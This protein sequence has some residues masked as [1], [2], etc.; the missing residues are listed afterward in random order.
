MPGVVGYKGEQIQATRS[1]LL[2]SIDT[3]SSPNACSTWRCP[4]SAMTS[5]SSDGVIM[6]A[7]AIRSASTRL[8]R[9]TASQVR[10]TEL[11]V[12]SPYLDK[13]GYLLY[14]RIAQACAGV[15]SR[16]P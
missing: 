10:E 7:A 11:R 12:L 1:H 2:T 5:N 15:H 16:S 3:G 8:L 13:K 9:G 4:F 14:T 6:T